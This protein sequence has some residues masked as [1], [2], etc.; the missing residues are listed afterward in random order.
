MINATA[1]PR[2]CKQE[3]LVSVVF[4]CHCNASI[5]ACS[6]RELKKNNGNDDNKNGI[7]AD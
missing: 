5:I 6:N 2:I 7:K 4:T 3:R 1:L